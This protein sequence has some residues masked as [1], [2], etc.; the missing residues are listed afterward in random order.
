MFP[1]A[2]VAKLSLTKKAEGGVISGWLK[3][4][5]LLKLSDALKL[6]SGFP[7]RLAKTQIAVPTSRVS[8]L[9]DQGWS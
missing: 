5:A 1:P 4:S 3:T 2:K 9:V 7:E 8:H 6:S